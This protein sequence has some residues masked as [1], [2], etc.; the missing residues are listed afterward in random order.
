M[1]SSDLRR[2]ENFK[3]YQR[4]LQNEDYADVSF[5]E[6]SGGL[7]AIHKFH[8]FD[9]Q[10]SPKG[11]V[12]GDYERTVL[13]VLR[14]RGHR[15]VLESER[16]LQGIKRCDGLLD[17]MPV[18]IKAIEGNGMWAISTKLREA[19]KQHAQSVI[20]YF[21]DS[22]KYSEARIREGIRLYHTGAKSNNLIETDRILVIVKNELVA[23]QKNHPDSGWLIPEGL[24]GQNGSPR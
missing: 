8:K 23:E 3:E 21:P 6:A 4:L 16:G 19:E 12:R 17:D 2:E 9:K 11:R 24:G 5:D 13:K 22:D 1:R 15:I 10:R 7:S 14:E 20:L 18:E